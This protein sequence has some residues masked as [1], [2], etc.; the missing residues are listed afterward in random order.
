MKKMKFDP[1]TIDYSLGEGAAGDGYIIEKE[2]YRFPATI[3]SGVSLYLKQY[4]MK[5][6]F[7]LLYTYNGKKNSY[8]INYLIYGFRKHWNAAFIDVGL[9]II[10]N[11]EKTL[12]YNSISLPY[13]SFGLVLL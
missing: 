5:I 9:A 8:A 11:V 13:F 2:Y 6:L 12:H 10:T 1:S 7:E 3:Q 4:K